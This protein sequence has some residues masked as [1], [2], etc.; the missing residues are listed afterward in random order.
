MVNIYGAQILRG[1]S[2]SVIPETGDFRG[3]WK[4]H[5]T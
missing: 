1:S 4:A 2:D 5:V 3:C